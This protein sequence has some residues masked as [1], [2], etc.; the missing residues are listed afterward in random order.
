MSLPLPPKSI[1]RCDDATARSVYAESTSVIAGHPQATTTYRFYEEIDAWLGPWGNTGYP[2]AYGKFYNLAF[3]GN[4]KLMGNANAAEWVRKTTIRLHEALRDFLVSRVRNCTIGGLTEGELRQAAFD[5]HPK[6]YDDGG[7]AM[8][9]LVAP[10]LVPVIATIPGKEF[11]PTSDNFGAT[12]NQVL[13]TAVRL[14]P[15]LTGNTLAAM[16]GPA[17]TGLFQMAVERDRQR[18]MGE[19]AIGRELDGI[20]SAIQRGQID[21]IPFLDFVIN[22]L[23]ATEFPDQ[24]FAQMARQV[25]MI[26]Q[27]RKQMLRRNYNQMLE[28]SP[29]V[30]DRVEKAFPRLL[31]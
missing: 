12:V 25:I 5:S 29:P 14:A 28:Q 23:N 4:A 18:F 15:E 2:I 24:G 6:A 7:L 26:A 10:E 20:R 31:R 11:I 16:A 19:M 17:H 22:R 3:T 21:Y 13:I 9:V 8:V 1:I 27:A 30:K